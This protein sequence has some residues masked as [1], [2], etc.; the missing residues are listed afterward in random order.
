MESLSTLR[1]S[2]GGAEIS[3]YHSSAKLIFSIGGADKL[4]VVDLT[5]PF[6]PALK[7]IISLNGNT[8]S[9]AINKD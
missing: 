1:L 9:V 5:N 4:S 7:E 6:A 2:V 3:S 8:N